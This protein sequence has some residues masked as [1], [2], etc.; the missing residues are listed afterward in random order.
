MRKSRAAAPFASP[1]GMPKIREDC[2]S[3]AVLPKTAPPMTVTA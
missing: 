3:P 2:K 1:G